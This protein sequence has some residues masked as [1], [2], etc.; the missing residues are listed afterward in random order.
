MPNRSQ[1]EQQEPVHDRSVST[2][3][4][5]PLPRRDFLATG[6]ASAALPWLSAVTASP[7][8]AAAAQPA[9]AAAVGQSIIGGY[10]PWAAGL[11]TDP[12]RFS[13]RRSDF[14]DLDAWQ[15]Q[16]R[17]KAAE[18]IASPASD[19][20]PE[21]EVTD[22][23]RYDGL[24]IEELTWQLSYG[25]PT[26]AVVLKPA[27]AS[28]RLPAVLGLHDHG[29]SKYFGHRKITRTG[30]D[31]HPLMVSHQRQYYD[32]LAW[33]NELARRGYVVLV[34][35]TFPF[36]SRRVRFAEMTPIPWGAA[37]TADHSDVDPENPDQIAAYNAWAAAHEH[38]MAKS[39][40]CAGTTWPGVVLGEDQRALD[41][42]CRRD[43][44]D[45][46]RAGC[47]GLS[48]GGLR[49]VYLGG[50]DPRIRCAVCVGFMSTW[51]DF[52]LNKAY[53]HTWMTY[54]PLLPNLLE[55]PE[56]LGLRVPLPTMVQNCTE[57]QLYTVPEMRTA[58]RI[59]REVYSKAGADQ[60][61]QGR[62]YS[63]GHKFDR[64]MQQDAFA[65]FDRWLK[66]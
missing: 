49:T 47:A 25:P 64:P 50:L 37:A 12:P 1:P 3:S 39:L 42:L 2:G 17:A 29:G 38:V 66:A 19:P 13:F 53:T 58:D 28:G 52:L 26:K 48:V 63:G 21:P 20:A 6:A 8:I 36:A 14:T 30:P 23:R 54:A 31:S 57:D 24:E 10:G 11:A 55:F 15:E 59:L 5:S 65:W 45:P 16:A 32:D 27:G 61:Y 46:Q 44:V 7:S 62:F 9:A 4:A 60:K 22:R 18:L 41:I 34:H 43:D 35:D 33:A 56:I 51:N 40:F